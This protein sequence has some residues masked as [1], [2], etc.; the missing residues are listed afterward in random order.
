M[1]YAARRDIVDLFIGASRLQIITFIFCIINIGLLSSFNNIAISKE[2]E[3]TNHCDVFFLVKWSVIL[4]NVRRNESFEQFIIVTYKIWRYPSYFYSSV[5]K[6][7]KKK[8]GIYEWTKG[9]GEFLTL[10]G[11]GQSPPLFTKG[12][13]T[14]TR[15]AFSILVEIIYWRKNQN[16]FKFSLRSLL[17]GKGVNYHS[18]VG[19]EPA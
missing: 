15:F 3:R 14:L 6:Y 10:G 19:L 8:K 5:N 2:R 1:I 7:K 4:S 17:V 9:R 13:K 18:Q 11:S 16:F 12:S